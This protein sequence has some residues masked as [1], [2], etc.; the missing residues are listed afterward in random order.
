MR[1]NADTD[2]PLHPSLPHGEHVAI[3]A[4]IEAARNAEAYEATLE[5]MARDIE[6]IIARQESV[7]S[8][9]LATLGWTVTQIAEIAPE[10]LEMVRNRALRHLS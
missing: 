4:A 1:P 9:D 2:F 5:R 8:D 3:H 6:A 7:D 10:A